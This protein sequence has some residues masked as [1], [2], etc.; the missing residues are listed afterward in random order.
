MAELGRS[1]GLQREAGRFAFAVGDLVAAGL[2]ACLACPPASARGGAAVTA[3]PARPGCEAP[4]APDR[5]TRIAGGVVELESGLVLR[6]ADIRLAENDALPEALHAW[7]AG[8]AGA[9][10]RVAAAPADRWGVRRGRVLVGAGEGGIDLAELL[11]AEGLAMVDPGEADGLCR[12][13]L[14]GIENTT[15]S[16]RLGLWHEPVLV[17]ADDTAALTARTGRFTIVEGRV[18][19]VGERAGRTYLNFTRFGMGGFALTIPRR[20]W[21]A[22]ARLGVSAESLRGRRVRVRGVPEMWRTPTMEMV[23][24]DMLERL[25]P[26]PGEAR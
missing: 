22:L 16:G 7:A 26:T 20:I 9:A 4:A 10:V 1:K 24:P 6:L 25:D 18:V 23:A 17:A 2:L 21:T 19:S 14:L 11:V 15:R 12:P 3:P 5:I 8:F 13:D